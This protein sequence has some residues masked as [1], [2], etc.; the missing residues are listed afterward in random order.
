MDVSEN[1]LAS[2]L[3]KGARKVALASPAAR[4]AVP[5]STAS[6]DGVTSVGRSPLGAH[7]DSRRQSRGHAL[8]VSWPVQVRAPV[9][10]Q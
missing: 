8:A 7:F 6:D 3:V 2:A 5:R 4:I 1:K 10:R 9:A